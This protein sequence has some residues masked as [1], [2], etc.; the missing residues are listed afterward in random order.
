MAQAP[1]S[2]YLLW[3]LDTLLFLLTL[4]A[5]AVAFWDEAPDFISMM[6]LVSFVG[7]FILRWRMDDNRHQYLKSNWLDLALIVLLA[8]PFLRLLVA[9]RIAGLIPALRIGVL[10]RAN[11]KHIL[12]L[13]ILSSDS[14]PAAM[15]LLFL[16]VFF[17]GSVTFLFEHGTNPQFHHISDGLWWAFVT[18]ATVGYGDIVPVTSGGRIVAVLTMIFGIAVYS[19]LVANVTYY[20]EEVGRKRHLGFADEELSK[21]KAASKSDEVATESPNQ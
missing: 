15:T 13:I 6:I 5:V 1:R 7:F 18:L 21:T 10:V 11:K 2:K 4:A 20:V 3:G 14:L 16:V 8:S 17:F 12:K 9:F 19:L